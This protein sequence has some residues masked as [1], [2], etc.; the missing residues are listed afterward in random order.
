[1]KIALFTDSFLP[2]IGG[3]ENV[4]LHLANELSKNHSVIVFAPD[5]HRPYEENLSLPFKVVRA[6]SIAFTKNECWAFP[7]L[8]AKLKKE[9]K[10]FKP[11]VIHTHTIG[12]M[13]GFAN[14]YGKKN[15]VPIVCTVHT[16]FRYCYKNVLKLDI[17]VKILLAHVI[18][19]AN[20]AD[21]VC[22]VCNS[23][24]EELKSYG[25]KNKKVTVIRNGYE[26][27]GDGQIK[28]QTNEKFTLLFV[29]LLAEYKNVAFSLNC[30]KE[31]KKRRSDF[32]FYVV[33]RGPQ[34][35]KIKILAQKLGLNEN[36]IFTGAITD[37]EKLQ[38]VYRESDLFLFTSLIDN[39]ALVLMES[40]QCNTPSLV[41][42]NTGSAERFIN[43]QTGFIVKNDEKAVAD[44]IEELMSDR[45]KLVFVG[46]NAKS[47]VVAW[48]Q[49]TEQY[50]DVYKQEIEKKQKAT[51][52]K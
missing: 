43:D 7:S 48:K 44:K 8:T 33:G 35:K 10:E 3:T 19:R 15:N 2:G 47:V 38:K 46:Q 21:R 30:L 23:M 1:M 40:A 37:K 29:G 27:S 51:N 13:A 42:E 25:L 36:V 5:Y 18:K 52:N 45:E 22:S 6:K 24:A 9:L 34:E 41:I 4:V 20:K 50:L 26:K 32:V 28:K 49:V 11:D 31:L 17:L 12:M 14:A 16:K 39:D